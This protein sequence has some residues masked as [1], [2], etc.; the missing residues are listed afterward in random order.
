MTGR[1][2][3]SEDCTSKQVCIGLLQ[4]I[5]LHAETQFYNFHRKKKISTIQHPNVTVYPF[6]ANGEISAVDL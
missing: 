1:L 2:K 3:T 4:Q 5:L 6:D